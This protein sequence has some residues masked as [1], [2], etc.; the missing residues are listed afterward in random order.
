MQ[1]R[2]IEF[3]T[4]HVTTS[5]PCPYLKGRY[6]RKVFTIAPDSDAK[7]IYNTLSKL[8]FR[9]SQFAL[10]KT[11]CVDC[12]A[13]L[14]VRIRVR[15]FTPSR[16]QKRV[17]QKNRFIKRRWMAPIADL[18]QF[19]MFQ[20]YVQGRHDDGHMAH[21]EVSDYQKMVEESAVETGLIAYF[22]TRTSTQNESSPTPRLV[23]ACV[24]DVMD[25]GLSMVYSFFDPDYR[26]QSLGIYMILDHIEFAS[27]LS[28][29]NEFVYLG[30]WVPTCQKMDYKKM[31]TPI[32]I[33]RGGEWVEGR[34]LNEYT[35]DFF[36]DEKAT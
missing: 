20:K 3:P 21:M 10:Y 1:Y 7:T 6:E 18:S 35:P 33:L 5:E 26:R 19:E 29:D 17:W 31:F 9:R 25:D 22:D 30:Y 16:S 11:A 34:R 32:E 27:S 12:E 15:D 36:P 2:Q 24:T 14:P 8:G 23:A 28:P 4:F 13:C